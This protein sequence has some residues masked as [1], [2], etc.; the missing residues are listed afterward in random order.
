LREFLGTSAN[1]SKCT[2]EN[3]EDIFLTYFKSTKTLEAYCDKPL[4]I[5][6]RGLGY[7]IKY[8]LDEFKS[9][10]N[11]M[12]YRGNFLFEED[13]TLSPKEVLNVLKRRKKGYYGSRMHFFRELWRKDSYKLRYYLQNQHSEEVLN[14]DSLVS[15]V[16]N[17]V[18]LMRPV[19]LIK[20]T[21]KYDISYIKFIDGKSIPFSKFGFFDS[22][23]LHWSGKMA[24]QRI[25]DLLPFEYWP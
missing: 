13:T 15:E 25:G 12:F 17:N 3:I 24:N 23:F 18:R 21:Y 22:E 9:S 16:N 7:N 11:N 5:H 20:I 10:Q 4:L 14:L 6:N 2:I 1:A 19:G 8:F